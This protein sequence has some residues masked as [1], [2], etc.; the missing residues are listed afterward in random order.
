MAGSAAPRT[1]AG[2]TFDERRGSRRARLIA[3]GLELL[4]TVGR[5]RTT[6]RAVCASAQLTPRYFYESFDDLD[7]LLATVLDQI[8]AEAAGEVFAA[9]EAAPPDVRSRSRATVESFV[10]FTVDDPRRARIVFA[11][12]SGSEPLEQRR[13]AALAAFAG[14]AS[15][16][17]RDLFG[18]LPE[19]EP[20][21]RTTALLLAGGIA[22]VLLAFVAG[23]LE[24][25]REQLITDLSELIEATGAEAARIAGHRYAQGG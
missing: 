16:Q 19:S 9:V 2:A 4:G 13:R 12:T 20:L 24:T 21:I 6:V 11:E 17:A 22:E 5:E 25:T 23:E 15:E 10:A 8:L 14:M 1:Y 3:A 7:A 18:D